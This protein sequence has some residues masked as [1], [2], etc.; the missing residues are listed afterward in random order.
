MKQGFGSRSKKTVL[1]ESVVP[2]TEAQQAKVLSHLKLDGDMYEVSNVQ[3]RAL[4]AG[5]RVSMDGKVVDLSFQHRLQQ[6]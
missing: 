5:I 6:L 3:N 4:V 2:L 1:V